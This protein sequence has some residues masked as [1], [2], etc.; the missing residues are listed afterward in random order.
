MNALLRLSQV[1]ATNQ[2]EADSEYLKMLRTV[3][4]DGEI[5]RIWA[6]EG[7][8]GPSA[9]QQLP[10]W[11]ARP[12][13]KAI[14]SFME[15]FRKWEETINDRKGKP[16]T[17]SQQKRYDE[18]LQDCDCVKLLFNSETQSHVTKLG[19]ASLAKAHKNMFSLTLSLS[20][21]P[22]QIKVKAGG[23][24]HGRKLVLLESEGSQESCIL[25]AAVLGAGVDPTVLDSLK[26][27]AQKEQEEE[28][29][30]DHME[31]IAQQD[32]LLAADND[33][34]DEMEICARSSDEDIPVK[35]TI[36][37]VKEFDHRPEFIRLRSLGLTMLPAHRAGVYLSHHTT[38]R[39]W[40]S[41]Y[42]GTTTG[43]SFTYGG[44]TKRISFSFIFGMLFV[45]VWHAFY[46]HLCVQLPVVLFFEVMLIFI[47]IYLHIYIYSLYIS[48]Y[49][50]IL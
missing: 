45:L 6:I 26:K 46:V 18:W 36:K 14:C 29:D 19:D 40:Q 8:E 13:E 10:S 5:H 4:L 20:A 50:F 37:R 24:E 3:P 21:D 25:P 32:A 33:I 17:A 12:I 22:S 27:S 31:T 47:Y 38:T 30:D 15:R 49:L 48:L 16:L 43:L 2:L 41:F 11:V 34:E 7:P 9:R 1:P 35:G 28:L 39:C 23:E 42:P 44:K